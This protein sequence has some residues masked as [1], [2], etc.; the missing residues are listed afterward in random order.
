MSDTTTRTWPSKS[1]SSATGLPCS[2]ARWPVQCCSPRTERCS[3]DS[4]DSSAVTV[5]GSSSCNP[6]R[7]SIGTGA[8]SVVVG[9]GPIDRGGQAFRLD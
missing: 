3:P 2:V 7:C 5:K 9:T 8:W 1:S 6:T 4:A